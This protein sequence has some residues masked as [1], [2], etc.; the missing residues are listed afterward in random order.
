MSKEI[1]LK[2]ILFHYLKGNNNFISEV[3]KKHEENIS[4]QDNVEN[5]ILEYLFSLSDLNY[6]DEKLIKKISKFSNNIALHLTLSKYYKKLLLKNFYLEDYNKALINAK[7]HLIFLFKAIEISKFTL[8]NEEKDNFLGKIKSFVNCL[9][10]Q[11]EFKQ[12]LELKIIPKKISF[13][14]DRSLFKKP[15]GI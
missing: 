6:E 4:I 14:N 7:K 8:T 2:K 11:C 9:R 12:A 15:L 3:F 10:I 1:L 13:V 5:L